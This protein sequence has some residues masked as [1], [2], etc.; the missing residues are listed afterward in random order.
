[1]PLFLKFVKSDMSL[2][3]ATAARLIIPRNFTEHDMRVAALAFIGLIGVVIFPLTAETSPAGSGRTE[4]GSK[5]YLVEIAQ[6]CGPGFHWVGK[7]RNRYGAW[8]P[9]HCARN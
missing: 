7:H 9:G 5:P 6:G 3:R 1:L 8:V 2:Y 4:A